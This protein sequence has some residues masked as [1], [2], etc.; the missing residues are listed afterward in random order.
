MYSPSVSASFPPALGFFGVSGLC[1]AVGGAAVGVHK[2][3]W[4]CVVAEPLPVPSVFY[5]VAS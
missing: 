5:A 1:R 2:S 4:G 3:L